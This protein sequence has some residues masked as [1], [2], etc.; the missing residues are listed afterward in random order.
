[1]LPSYAPWGHLEA[2][3][4]GVTLTKHFVEKME[5][6]VDIFWRV[7]THYLISALLEKGDML[8]ND[9]P[10]AGLEIYQWGITWT[11]F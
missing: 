7:S 11:N 6:N 10:C 1:M 9:A 4:G 5:K 8:P 3:W 2:Y